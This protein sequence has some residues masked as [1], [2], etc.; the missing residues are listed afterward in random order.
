M[1]WMR[2][3]TWNSKFSR[4]VASLRPASSPGNLIESGSRKL[5]GLQKEEVTSDNLG[6]AFLQRVGGAKKADTNPLGSP[7]SYQVSS[8]QVSSY[9]VS[10]CQVSYQVSSCQVS[11]QVS[12]CQVSSYQVSSCQVSS[13]QV[14]SCQVSYQVSSCQVSYQVSSCQVSSY[15]VSSCQV[16]YQVSSCQVSYQVSCQVSR[17]S[18]KTTPWTIWADLRETEDQQTDSL[19]TVTRWTALR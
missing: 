8:C 6:G 16:S 11:Y 4:C 7:S 13:Y 18:S 19:W 5:R 1:M 14:S 10:S 15:Q 2:M 9:Q 17:G 12:S 3:I